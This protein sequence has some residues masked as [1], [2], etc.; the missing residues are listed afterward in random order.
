MGRAEKGLL[1]EGL[2]IGG[3]FSATITENTPKKWKPFK[4]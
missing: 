1:S 4:P 2:P 3:G